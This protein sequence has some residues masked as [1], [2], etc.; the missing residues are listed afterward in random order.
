[1]NKFQKCSFGA[2]SR[3]TSRLKANVEA[4]GREMDR[5]LRIDECSMVM[6]ATVRLETGR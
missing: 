2:V 3:S 4:G 1:M 6:E 5:E